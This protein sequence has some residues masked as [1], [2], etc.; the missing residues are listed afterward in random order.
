MRRVDG[1]SRSPAR[2][3]SCLLNQVTTR[4]ADN[5]GMRHCFISIVILLSYVA[6]TDVQAAS[7]LS[8]R[9]GTFG[10]GVDFDQRISANL[11]LRAGY[12]LYVHGE[13]TDSNGIHYDAA[14]RVNAASLILDW[15]R[16]TS[17]WRFSIGLSQSGPYAEANGSATGTVIVNGQSYN[18]YDLGNLTVRIK[19]RQALAPYLGFGRGRTLGM[20]DRFGFLFDLGVL[21]T[22]SP[23]GRVDA[24]CGATLASD[25]CTQ[26]LADIQTELA[27]DEHQWRHYKWW[28]V[29][30]VGFAMRW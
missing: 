20:E 16:G 3:E 24:N 12:N 7:A 15:H 14:L 30:S 17:P 13:K 26:L 22:G 19:P 9:V 28:P 6:V 5:H 23:R 25:Q 8:Y 1:R 2:S 27:K 11:S 29:L 21:Y 10:F 18:A 4:V